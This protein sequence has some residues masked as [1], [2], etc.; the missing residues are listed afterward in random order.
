MDDPLSTSSMARIFSFNE[1]V[2][3]LRF[4]G[5]SLRGKKLRF[6]LMNQQESIIAVCYKIEVD[7]GGGFLIYVSVNR[8]NNKYWNHGL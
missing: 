4:G 1:H 3:P 7:Q 8:T 5:I 6:Y 2:R